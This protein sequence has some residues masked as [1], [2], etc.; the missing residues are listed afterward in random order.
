MPRA[1][2][3][4]RKWTRPP[5]LAARAETLLFFLIGRGA[6][7]L[8]GYGRAGA[9]DWLSRPPSH[10]QRSR[11]R[12]DEEREGLKSAWQQRSDWSGEGGGGRV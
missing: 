4:N 5:G 12:P 10:P 9:C 1:P 8:P 11:Q 7:G 3:A 6:A 2:R